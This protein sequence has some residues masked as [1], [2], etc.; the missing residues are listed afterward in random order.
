MLSVGQS[1]Q[2]MRSGRHAKATCIYDERSASN[3]LRSVA[4]HVHPLERDDVFSCV[5][6]PKINQCED[7]LLLVSDAAFPGI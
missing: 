2:N 1:E 3:E 6:H 4:Q 7:Y 5:Q